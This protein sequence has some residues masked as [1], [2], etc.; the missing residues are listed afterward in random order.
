MKNVRMIKVKFNNII[1][2]KIKIKNMIKTITFHNK[3]FNAMR[4]LNKKENFLEA[5]LY[6]KAHKIK[7]K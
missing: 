2:N 1:R 3:N 4:E 7:E 5:N 6:K